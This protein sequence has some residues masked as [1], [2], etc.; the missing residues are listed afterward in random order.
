M[1]TMPF[2]IALLVF[3]AGSLYFD[4]RRR[5]IPNW[6]TLG[7]LPAAPALWASWSRHAA[8]A[9]G[10]P[11]PVL[12]AGLSVAGALVCAAVPLVLFRLNMM[13]G[14]DVKLLA[15]VGALALPGPGLLVEW[16][17]FLLAALLLPAR[18]AYHGR[19]MATVVRATS[20]MA[21]PLRA[22]GRR[23]PMPEAMSERVRLTPFV[24]VA[25]IAAT[26]F[27]RAGGVG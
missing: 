25:A 2:Q 5:T 16:L 21:N 20:A 27:E 6:L 4:A 12:F 9:F 17:S 15:C 22:E 13:G 23:R 1:R 14:G 19:L 10:V 18:L 8:G 11:G 7:V 26:L 24:L 3:L